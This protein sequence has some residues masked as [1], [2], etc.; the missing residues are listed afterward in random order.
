MTE[1]VEVNNET[2]VTVKNNKPPFYVV[3]VTKLII[4]QIFTLGLYQIIWFYWHFRRQK[5]HHN[6]KTI[7]VLRSIFS[8]FFTHTLFGE[9]AAKDQKTGSPVPWKPVLSATMV[10]ITSLLGGVLNAVERNNVHISYSDLYPFLSITIITFF[11]SLAQIAANHVCDDPKGLS[12]SKLTWVN[13][14]FIVIG[15]IFILL[16]ILSLLILYFENT[17]V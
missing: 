17:A 6:D 12:N 13:Y 5:E 10:V 9:I 16:L 8:I 15:F 2:A 3:S 4:L 11:I 1:I 14:I 7:P